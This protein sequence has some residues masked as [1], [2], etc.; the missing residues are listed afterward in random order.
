MARR[1]LSHLSHD[2]TDIAEITSFLM[3]V[4]ALLRHRHDAADL[5]VLLTLRVSGLLPV[6]G[7]AV[8]FT[9]GADGPAITSVSGPS[10]TARL[11]LEAYLE[12]DAVRECLVSGRPVSQPGPGTDSATIHA[13]PIDSDDTVFGALVLLSDSPLADTQLRVARIFTDV[14]SVVFLRTSRHLL[15]TSSKANLA[16]LLRSLDVIEQAKG[17]LSQRHGTGV[18][19]AFDGLW[20]VGLDHGI[21]LTAL[22]ERVVARSLDAELA[23]SLAR[24]ITSPASAPAE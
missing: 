21:G 8:V 4:L 22:A 15:E 24:A 6:R 11:A 1:D 23:E 5:C 12:C 20:Q 17:M 3:D 14:A 2:G 10:E 13:L 16:D 18:D 7:A 19:A 9:D